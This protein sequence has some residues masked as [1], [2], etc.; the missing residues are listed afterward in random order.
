MLQKQSTADTRMILVMALVP[1]LAFSAAWSTRTVDQ[2]SAL[3]ATSKHNRIQHTA[4]ASHGA[5]GGAVLI[6]RLVDAHSRPRRARAP[7]VEN[8]NF[9][10]LWPK[11]LETGGFP[12]ILATQATIQPNPT[13]PTAP[14]IDPTDP[15]RRPPD[16]PLRYLTL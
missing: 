6:S 3:M 14:L 11:R 12:Y 7:C 1:D 10:I 13:T 5:Q 8:K 4:A 9:S 15:A 16:R 2:S